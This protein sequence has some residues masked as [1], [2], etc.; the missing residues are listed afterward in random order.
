MA[1]VERAVTPSAPARPW[2]LEAEELAK[3]NNI[4]GLR[5]LY[6]DAVRLKINAPI[7]EKIKE[8]ATNT[9]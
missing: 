5:S 8:I 2:L 1:K 6:S 7:I 3:S 9:N 4:A